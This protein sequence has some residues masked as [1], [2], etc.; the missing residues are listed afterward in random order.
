MIK[1]IRYNKGMLMCTA[2]KMQWTAAIMIIG[3]PIIIGK[4]KDSIFKDMDELVYILQGL[5]ICLGTI[6]YILSIVIM[7]MVLYVYKP[8]YNQQ[9]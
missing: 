1:L 5:S 3:L 2:V 6:G 8:L 7:I 9:E 4:L